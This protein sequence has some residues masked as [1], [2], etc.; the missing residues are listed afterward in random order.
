MN[1]LIGKTIEKIYKRTVRS[2]LYHE[3]R[4]VLIIKFTD[5]TR[6]RLE[7]WDYECYESGITAKIYEQKRA[8]KN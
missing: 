7:S 4:E 2:K 5:G 3:E 6:L 8:F 1:K